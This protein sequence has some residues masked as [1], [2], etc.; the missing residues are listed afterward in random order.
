MS[1]SKNLSMPLIDEG[2]SYSTGET[3]ITTINI[4]VLLRFCLHKY[5]FIQLEFLP[6][7]TICA[8][9]SLTIN[10]EEIKYERAFFADFIYLMV[11]IIPAFFLLFFFIRLCEST[12]LLTFHAL[13][14]KRVHSISTR[15]LHERKK[16]LRRLISNKFHIFRTKQ[17]LLQRCLCKKKD[18]NKSFLWNVLFVYCQQ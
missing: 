14:N 15:S 2:N 8:L 17:Q 13:D 6:S 3:W 1:S 9:L 12:F 10:L 7:S 18:I 16:K 5:H 11:A 4:A